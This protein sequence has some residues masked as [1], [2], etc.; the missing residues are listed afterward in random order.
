MA[1]F[2]HLNLRDRVEGLCQ[3]K[4][5]KKEYSDEELKESMTGYISGNT[6]CKGDCIEHINLDSNNP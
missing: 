3:C 2:F 5:R 1:E 6:F 4:N